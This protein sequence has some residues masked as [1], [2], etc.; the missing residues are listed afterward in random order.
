M[1]NARLESETLR[2]SYISIKK[3]K[4][5]NLLIHYGGYVKGILKY[6]RSSLEYLVY[7]NIVSKEY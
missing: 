7:L 3:K 4:I 2:E 1:I 5:D 6:F